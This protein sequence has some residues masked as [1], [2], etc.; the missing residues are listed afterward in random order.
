[1]RRIDSVMAVSID[2][3]LCSLK[4]FCEKEAS[5]IQLKESNLVFWIMFLREKETR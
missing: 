1:M 4:I 2:K 5:P 3:Q